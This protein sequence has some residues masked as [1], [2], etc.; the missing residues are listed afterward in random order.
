MLFFFF[1]S[2]WI[3]IIHFNSKYELKLIIIHN[4]TFNGNI[5]S[6]YYRNK[7]TFDIKSNEL[8]NIQSYFVI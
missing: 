6:T 2:Y 1:T 7:Q 4:M 3:F 8:E 5:L